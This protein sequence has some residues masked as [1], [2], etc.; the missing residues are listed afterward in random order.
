[1]LKS[2]LLETNALITSDKDIFD[3]FVK[4]DLSQVEVNLLQE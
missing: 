3:L 1:M 4:A 2:G